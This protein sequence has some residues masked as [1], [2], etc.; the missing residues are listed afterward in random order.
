[1]QRQLGDATYQQLDLPRLAQSILKKAQ[2][3]GATLEQAQ[4]FALEG[5]DWSR[6]VR[7]ETCCDVVEPRHGAG[8]NQGDG[9][10]CRLSSASFAS[11]RESR[12][13]LLV[14]SLRH[15]SHR[16]ARGCD[17]GVVVARYLR[18][19]LRP[20]VSLVPRRSP[21]RPLRVP[22]DADY[23]V[24]GCLHAADDSHGAASVHPLSRCTATA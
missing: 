16:S 3:S 8:G 10:L 24:H 9:I 6:H 4:A 5:T 1:M 23:G 12:V 18:Q 15:L 2:E 21:P 17:P 22:A 14:A 20:T 11:D 13:H 19:V 7:P